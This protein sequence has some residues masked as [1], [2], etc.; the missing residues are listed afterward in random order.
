MSLSEK[1]KQYAIL[2]TLLDRRNICDHQ[3]WTNYDA[4]NIEITKWDEIIAYMC[5]KLGTQVIQ[6]EVG[7]W[8]MTFSESANAEKPTTK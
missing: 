7:Q 4:K 2:A 1:E 3:I 6:E 8:R 5:Q